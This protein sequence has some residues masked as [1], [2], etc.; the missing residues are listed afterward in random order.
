MFPPIFAPLFPPLEISIYILR[1]SLFPPIFCKPNDEHG[2]MRDGQQP[3]CG[4]SM[5][6][7]GFLSPHRLAEDIVLR[8][9]A[10]DF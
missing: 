8:H 9:I 3:L 5:S 2:Q 1:R 7:R 10:R 6:L 4:A